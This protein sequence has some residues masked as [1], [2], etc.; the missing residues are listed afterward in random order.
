M[1][2]VFSDKIRDYFQQNTSLILVQ[3]DGDLQFE[4]SVVGYNLQPVAPTAA[5][6]GQVQ[7]VSSLT[8]LTLTVKTAYVNTKEENDDFERNFSFFSDFDN[9]T[10]TLN[11]IEDQLVEEIFDQ[12]IL[13]IFNAT[14]ANW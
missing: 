4:G 11:D 12:I 13:D 9:T 5:V 14:V 3:E 7:D 2:Q 8:R 6:G 10:Q 1:G